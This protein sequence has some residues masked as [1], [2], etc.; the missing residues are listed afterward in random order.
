MYLILGLAC[1]FI[2]FL[3]V[4]ALYFTEDLFDDFKFPEY[5]KAVVGGLM[6]GCMGLAFPHIL[7]VG[8]GSIDLALVQKLSWWLMLMLILVKILATSITIGSGGSGGIFAPSLFLGA[9]TGGA[10]GLMVHSLFPTIT[11]SPGAYAIVGMAAVVSATTH[12]SLT[13]ILMLFE[14]TGEYRIILPLM[15]TCIVS[16]LAA[17]NLSRESIY[18]LKLVRRGVDIRE[19]REVNILKSISVK[20][21]MNS[22]VETVTEK[23]GLGEISERVA[24]SKHNSFPVLDYAGKLIGILSYNDYRDALFDED[25]K[26]LVIARDLATMNLVTVTMENNLYDALQL[27]SQKD[28]SII[29][30]VSPKNASELVGVVSRRDIVGAYEKALIKISLLNRAK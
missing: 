26:D 10:F 29:P 3:F 9:M 17:R 1:A 21:V 12:G 2:G 23:M 6:L 16:T 8:Y 4:K 5:L 20:D 11:A 14:M 25:L 28:F 18:T 7:G 13:A 22:K 27:I 30:V 15:M 19:G 24:K